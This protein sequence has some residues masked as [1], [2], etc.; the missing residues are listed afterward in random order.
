MNSLISRSLS[1]RVHT[2]LGLFPAVGI[3]GPR[4]VGKTT[5]VRE[6]LFGDAAGVRVLDLEN[7]RDLRLLE[8]P[9]DYLEAQSPY[10]VVIDEIQVMPSLFT[11]PKKSSV[12]LWSALMEFAVLSS[13]K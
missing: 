3:V 1:T 4:Q 2:L 10:T 12:A 13:S 6:L 9:Y 11:M 5:L 7:P 8:E